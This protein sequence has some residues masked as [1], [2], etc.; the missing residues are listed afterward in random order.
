MNY[1]PEDLKRLQQV[2]LEITKDID[3]VCRQ[4]NITYFLDSGS[5]LGAVRHGGFIPWDDDMDLGMLR[6]DYDRFLEV[7]PDALGDAYEVVH[8]RNNDRLAGQ[9]IKVWKKGTEF[10][11]KETIEAGVNQGIFVDVFPYDEVCADEQAAEKQLKDC[12]MWQSLSYLYHAKTIVVPHGGIKGA[13]E[14]AGCVVAHG[15]VR[16]A[17]N[18]EKIR[19]EFERSSLIGAGSGSNLYANMTYTQMGA[20]EKDVLVPPVIMGFEGVELCVPAQ[21]IPY[22]EQVYGA[23]WNELPPEDQ[24][25]N[26]APERLSFGEEG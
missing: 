5:C 18:P 3:R 23:T 15:L 21:A 7:A 2:L 6:A 16:L 12:R 8:P 17:L 9:F 1:K 20:F 11:T 19:S 26:H 24:R 22:L 13:I 10:A 14:K 4:H 25:R